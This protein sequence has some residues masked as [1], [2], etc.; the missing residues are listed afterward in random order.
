[1]AKAKKRF[2]VTLNRAWCKD[3]GICVAFCPAKVFEAGERGEALVAREEDCTGCQSC[4]LR[5]P[6][7]ALEVEEATP[8]QAA[9]AVTHGG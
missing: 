2:R 3:C 9:E 1:M 4:V 7:L 6:D 5:C 8:S